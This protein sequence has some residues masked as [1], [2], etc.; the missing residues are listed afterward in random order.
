M[1]G[2]LEAI[3]AGIGPVAPKSVRANARTCGRATD[4]GETLEA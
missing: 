1:T 2:L 4:F 3:E